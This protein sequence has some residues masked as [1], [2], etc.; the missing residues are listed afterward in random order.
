MQYLHNL[1]H[2]HHHVCSGIELVLSFNISLD[3]PNLANLVLRQNNKRNQPK[4]LFFSGEIEF[5]VSSPEYNKPEP[6]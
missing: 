5:Q 4:K 1:E 2:Y 3:N 6:E